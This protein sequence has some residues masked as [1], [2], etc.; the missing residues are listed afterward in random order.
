MDELPKPATDMAALEAD[1]IRDAL[2]PDALA[3]VSNL[4]VGAQSMPGNPHDGHTLS[5][6]LAQVERLT[7]SCQAHKHWSTC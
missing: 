6:A 2:E 3:A 1:L 4:V 5:T 7:G